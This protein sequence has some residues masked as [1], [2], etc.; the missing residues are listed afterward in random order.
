MAYGKM[1]LDARKFENFNHFRP[2]VSTQRVKSMTSFVVSSFFDREIKKTFTI[3]TG[4]FLGLFQS[5][6]K[7]YV[8]Q[9]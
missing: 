6:N 1:N 8:D 7:K 9:K 2:T 4:T 5:R 3:L